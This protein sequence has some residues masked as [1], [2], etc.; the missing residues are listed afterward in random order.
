MDSKAIKT[1]AG[2]MLNLA[3]TE[4][5][6]SALKPALEGLR[7]LVRTIEAVPLTFPGDPFVSPGTADAWLEQDWSQVHI[8]QPE[9]KK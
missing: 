3:L 1:V 9:A 6:A 2:E 7:E 8:S 4:D 5:E